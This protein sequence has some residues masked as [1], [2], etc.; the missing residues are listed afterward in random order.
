MK[1]IKGQLMFWSPKDRQ[2]FIDTIIRG[3]PI[4][5]L[6]LNY[7]SKEDVYYIVDGQQ[8]LKCILDY[9]LTAADRPEP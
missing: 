1:H 2:C 7:I 5:I 8:R 6:F 4:P 3:E 9:Y